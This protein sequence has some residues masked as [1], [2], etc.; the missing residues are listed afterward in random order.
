LALSIAAS[1]LSSLLLLLGTLTPPPLGAC[2]YLHIWPEDPKT[3][4]AGP[5]ICLASTQGTSENPLFPD[6]G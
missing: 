4:R 5:G 2:R 1:F 3:K 6:V